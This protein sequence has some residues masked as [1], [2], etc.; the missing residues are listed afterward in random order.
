[1]PGP[2]SFSPDLL[3]HLDAHGIKQIRY[4]SSEEGLQAFRAGDVLGSIELGPSFTVDLI[5]RHE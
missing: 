1:M 5:S 4:N 2:L 3:S